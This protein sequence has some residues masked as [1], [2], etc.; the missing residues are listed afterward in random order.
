M[1][2]CILPCLAGK[3]ESVQP[4]YGFWAPWIGEKSHLGDLVYNTEFKKCPQ[5]SDDQINEPVSEETLQDL[6]KNEKVQ[7]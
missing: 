3:E 5:Q 6:L 4:S 7:Y 1:C 2:T